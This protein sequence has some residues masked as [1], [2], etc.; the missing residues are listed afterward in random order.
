MEWQ[1]YPN[2]NVEKLD[3]N[4]AIF[5]NPITN[6]VVN[7]HVQTIWTKSK[8]WKQSPHCQ[9]RTESYLLIH[10]DKIV[11]WQ[12]VTFFVEQQ[13]AFKDFLNFSM[14]FPDSVFCLVSGYSGSSAS[15]AQLVL[16]ATVVVEREIALHIKKRTKSAYIFTKKCTKVYWFLFWQMRKSLVWDFIIQQN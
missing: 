7:D 3:Q 8:H 9:Q 11:P 15:F 2:L 12:V 4:V 14:Q 16:A 10:L 13:H 1:P 5:F 6:C